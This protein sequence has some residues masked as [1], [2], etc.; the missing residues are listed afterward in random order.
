MR[1]DLT[2][3]TV[4][5]DRSGS[6]E[7]I[8]ADAEG[9]INEFIE[10]QKNAEGEALLTFVEFDTEYDF[11]HNATPIK[12]VTPYVLKPRGMTAMLDAIGRAINE[13]GDRIRA[14]PETERPA[15]VV[16]VIATDGIE[17]ASR[18]FD[19]V[20]IK[21]MIERQQKQYS[22]KFVFLGAN[23][24][25]IASGAK[26]GIKASGAVDY[27]PTKIGEMYSMTSGKVGIMRCC[28]ARGM[29]SA[30]V[31]FDYTAAERNELKSE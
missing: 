16:F 5:Q 23:Q 17:N 26:I 14:M 4:V 25:A 9:G 24:D 22:W 11:V 15:L 6:M 7:Q 28:T 27:A 29:T 12:D 31:E 13:T 19:Y 21:E 10:Q 30:D 20:Q 8:K 18:E 3:I 1:Q 2:F